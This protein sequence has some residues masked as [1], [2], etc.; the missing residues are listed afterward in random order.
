[1][2]EIFLNKFSIYADQTFNTK[3]FFL[4]YR[5]LFKFQTLPVQNY[6]IV[7]KLDISL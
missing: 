6:Q 3:L 5:L 4:N 1:M 7:S 2:K